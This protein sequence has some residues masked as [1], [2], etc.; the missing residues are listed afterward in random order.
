[1]AK[2]AARNRISSILIF[3]PFAT[4]FMPESSLNLG[5]VLVLFGALNIVTARFNAWP[6]IP[7]PGT[8]PAKKSVDA[9]P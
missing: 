1:L 8:V 9:R 5:A 3:L 2:S 6:P 7:D 4:I